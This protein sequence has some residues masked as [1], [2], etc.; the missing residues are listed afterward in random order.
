MTCINKY[1][2]YHLGNN[3]VVV[4]ADSNSI[5]MQESISKLP[6]FVFN[7]AYFYFTN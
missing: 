7:I 6:I 1:L 3:Q 4:K 5:N 2:Q